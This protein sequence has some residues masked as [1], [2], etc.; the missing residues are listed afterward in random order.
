[1]SLAQIV[2]AILFFVW[3]LQFALAYLLFHFLI[4]RLPGHTRLA[5]EQFTRMV[6]E[7]VEQQNPGMKGHAKKALAFTGII[8]L[9]G[10]YGLPAPKHKA[11]DIMI[12]SAVF[13]LT[14][15]RNV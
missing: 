8:Q 6:V 1:M 7:Q 13:R 3:P 2:N 4:Q 11:M 10:D 9:C 5:H 12:E 14:Q 15:S